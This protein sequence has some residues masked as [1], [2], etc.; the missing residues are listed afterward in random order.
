MSDGHPNAP[1]DWIRAVQVLCPED[2]EARAAIAL[3]L[4]MQL[5][6]P[7][8]VGAP[9]Q[10][11]RTAPSAEPRAAPPAPV[12]PPGAPP[13]RRRPL[14]SD[15]TR[16][17]GSPNAP[18]DWLRTVP[19]LADVDARALRAPLPLE[20]L[21]EP[22]WAR[23]ILGGALATP[24]QGGEIDVERIIDGIAHALPVTA[25]PRSAA[26]TLARGVQVLIDLG[27]AMQPFAADQAA[28]HA[29]IV[30]VVGRDK[31]GTV[32]F[33]GCP[34]WNDGPGS[35]PE[36]GAYRPP[37]PGTP[38]L[39]LTDL[40]IGR[41][42]GGHDWASAHDWL[43][44]AAVARR[45]GCPLVAFVP[46]PPARYPAD[47]RGPITIVQWDRSTTVAAVRRLVGRGLRCAGSCMS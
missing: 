2:R 1:I 37:A 10:P 9:R 34:V 29:A 14:L 32:R 15:L 3:V 46:Y 30:R 24:G 7:A 33:A 43:A 17:E 22:R 23:A 8:D 21:F 45:A 5:R 26:P 36:R 41:P 28:V 35:A 27:E 42:A 25:I 13:P 12:E 19:H 18:P 4:G 6:E 40:G 31:T 11:Q 44:F 38:I 16:Q 39:A 20:P 47:V